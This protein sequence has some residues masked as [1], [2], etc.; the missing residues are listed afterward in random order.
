MPVYHGHTGLL[1]NTAGAAAINDPSLGITTLGGKQYVDNGQR[2]YAGM[3]SYTNPIALQAQGGNNDYK[4]NDLWMTGAIRITPLEGLII[5]A[6]YTFN[7]Y[8][9][10][11]K[12][13][14]QSFT[15]Y[16]AVAGTEGVYPWTNPSSVVMTNN[17]DYYT[18]FNAFAEYTKT[19]N[20]S[21]NFKVMAGYNQEYK[22]NK[23]FGQV[24]KD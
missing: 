23:Y 3:G 24:V 8:N 9:K 7:M 12:Q 6:D 1:Y 22:H 17:E 11:S 20:S 21:H 18:A 19:F 14:V 5:N 15:E 16:K 13:H 2:Y 10:G 4:Q